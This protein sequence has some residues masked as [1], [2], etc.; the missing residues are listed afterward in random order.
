MSGPAPARISADAAG[1]LACAASMSKRR[2]TEITRIAEFGLESQYTHPIFSTNH[3]EEPMTQT[4]PTPDPPPLDPRTERSF[5][6][7]G[8][9][10]I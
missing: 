7:C 5:G 4:M 9:R 1:N 10:W 2:P 8:S 6:D 3:T